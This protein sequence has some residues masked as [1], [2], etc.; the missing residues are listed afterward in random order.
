MKYQYLSIARWQQKL[1]SMSGAGQAVVTGS[2]SNI[3]SPAASTEDVFIL[4]KIRVFGAGFCPDVEELFR[5]PVRESHNARM[6]VPGMIWAT[7]PVATLRI[8]KK[9]GE[10]RTIYGA[11]RTTRSAMCSHWMIEEDRPRDALPF[12]LIYIPHSKKAMV[13]PMNIQ[14][15]ATHCRNTAETH[16]RPWTFQVGG[17]LD[18][19]LP[20][21]LPLLWP[22]HILEPSHCLN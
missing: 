21:Y 5:L 13:K 19:V 7:R 9:F 22:V 17:Q 11:D 18:N 15:D 2:N 16:W 8:S 3:C 1:A 20:V 4:P 14:V 10:N 6:F 12:L